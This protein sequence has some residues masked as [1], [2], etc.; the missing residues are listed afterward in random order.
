MFLLS[1]E[2]KGLYLF[3]A[4]KLKVSDSLLKKKKELQYSYQPASFQNK[5][6]KKIVKIL[7]NGAIR[8][9]GIFQSWSMRHMPYFIE[10][11]WNTHAVLRY[12]MRRV[13]DCAISV[14]PYFLPYVFFCISTDMITRLSLLLTEKRC[15]LDKARQ[16]GTLQSSGNVGYLTF[17]A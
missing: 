1:V 15:G 6:K 13:R 4:S 2:T 9:Y 3:T 14:V 10:S 11:Q 12:E 8:G 5:T 16:T 7:Q 17:S